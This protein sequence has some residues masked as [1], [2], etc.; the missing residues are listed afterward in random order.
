[1]AFINHKSSLQHLLHVSLNPSC[2]QTNR[3]TSFSLLNPATE[4]KA[5]F[6]LCC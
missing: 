1:M 3:H 4:D 2:L 6:S 5:L